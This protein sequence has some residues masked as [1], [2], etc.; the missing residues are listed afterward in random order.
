TFPL[1]AM[2]YPSLDFRHKFHQDHIHPRS[3]FTVAQLRKRDIPE[4]LHDEYL[5]RVD[6]IPNLQLLEGQPNIEKSATPFAEW[7]H[8]AYPGSLRRADYLSRQF[9]P[10]VSYDLHGFLAFFAGRRALLMDRLRQLVG[11][12]VSSEG[13]ELPEAA[14][15]E[16]VA[17]FHVECMKRVSQYLHED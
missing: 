4:S 12:D 6:L 1:L 13:E 17:G 3:H 16:D 5:E 14:S 2:L 15:G 11:V 10:A 9:M 7:L 8:V